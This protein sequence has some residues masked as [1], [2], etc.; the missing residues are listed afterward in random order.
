MASAAAQKFLHNDE[1]AFPRSDLDICL[2]PA[3]A[4]FVMEVRPGQTPMV[5]KGKPLSAQDVRDRRV[6]ST[7]PPAFE[8]GDHIFS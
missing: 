4:R 2:R 7:R 5:E 3:A 8:P 6:S 1:P